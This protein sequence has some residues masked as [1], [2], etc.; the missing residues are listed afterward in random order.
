MRIHSYTFT[1]T[2]LI[3]NT[4]R[5]LKRVKQHLTDDTVCVNNVSMI[6]TENTKR[7]LERKF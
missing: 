3:T 6:R 1:F 2:F 5:E 4:E 7:T